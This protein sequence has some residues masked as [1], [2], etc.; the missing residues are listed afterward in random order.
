MLEAVMSPTGLVIFSGLAGSGKATT[1]YTALDYINANSPCHICTVEDAM[2]VQITPKKAIVQ[3]REIG[4]D[5]PNCLAGIHAAARQDL[6]VLFIGEIKTFEELRA[7]ITI[8]ETGHL[9]ITVFHSAAMPEDVIRR[10]IDVT[11]DELRDVTRRALAGALRGISTQILLPKE[12]KG[13][14]AAYAV[15]IPDDEMRRA[16]LEERDFMD[17][18][19]LP[20]GSRTMAEDIEAL[21]RDGVISDATATRALAGL[22]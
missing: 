16:M 22:A 15:L 21:R 11:P 20:E 4:V 5:V 3:Q 19:T 12:A 6:D 1:A 10:M 14:T 13:R 9:V 2:T 7:A 8:A 17:R 18:K